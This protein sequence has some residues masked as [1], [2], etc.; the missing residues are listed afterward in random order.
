MGT[1]AVVT[2]EYKAKMKNK[3]V[4]KA[5]KGRLM[6]QDSVIGLPPRDEAHHIEETRNI[7]AGSIHR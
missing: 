2:T 4:E 7:H 6:L 1:A 5:K 3:K